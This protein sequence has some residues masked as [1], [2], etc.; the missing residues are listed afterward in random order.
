[1]ADE[2]GKRPR[3][4]EAN[5]GE[6]K[7]QRSE[8]T[9][10]GVVKWFDPTK[11]YGFI[12]T[13]GG[14]REIFVHQSA[15]TCKAGTKGLRPGER[16]SF[17][18]EVS[19]SGKESAVEVT[20]SDGRQ[21]QGIPD[22]Q[23][24]RVLP[25]PT[26]GALPE[27]RKRGICKWFKTDKGFGFITPLDGSADLFVHRS[28]LKVATT[29]PINSAAL[30]PME[31]L[32][33]SVTISEKDGKLGASDVTG[34]GGKNVAGEQPQLPQASMGTAGAYG[35]PLVSGWAQQPQ[36]VYSGYSSQGMQ[37]QQP[38]M[39]LGGMSGIGLM[40]PTYQMPTSVY[41]QRR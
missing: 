32:E 26:K 17:K 31:H 28:A 22:N 27:G 37:L 12:A 2:S 40:P 24:L 38:S 16:V 15:F 33:Y 1:M 23:V 18:S 41:Q 7:R 4:E 35:Q 19:E 14:E 25:G 20:G 29:T 30:A 21:V 3:E 34:P 10:E 6:A 39:M 36:Q 9:I 8:N 11:G 5:G 13:H